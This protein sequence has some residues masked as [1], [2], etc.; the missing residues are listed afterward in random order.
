MENEGE[1]D[2]CPVIAEKLETL[3]ILER[4]RPFCNDPFSIPEEREKTQKKQGLRNKK[5]NKKNEKHN[6]PKKQFLPI[7]LHQPHQELPN[8]SYGCAQKQLRLELYSSRWISQR[9]HL[10]PKPIAVAEVIFC[11]NN[12]TNV[13][14]RM[15]LFRTFF[16]RK[17]VVNGT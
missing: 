12:Y 13:L 16:G 6:P 4:K 8:Y 17:F 15:C 2:R 14:M 1:S 9:V 7:L 5:T 11:P 10:S 3:E